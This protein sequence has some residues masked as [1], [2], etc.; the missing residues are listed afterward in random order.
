LR[1]LMLWITGC[2]GSRCA[3]P[4]VVCGPGLP[5]EV[6]RL[7][8]LGRSVQA[9]VQALVPKTKADGVVTNREQARINQAQN[10]QSRRIHQRKHN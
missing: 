1:R 5:A 3:S 2:D 7:D 4:L 10:V 6:A 8:A 9:R